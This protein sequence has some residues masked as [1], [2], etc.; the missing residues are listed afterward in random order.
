MKFSWNKE[1]ALIAQIAQIIIALT[2]SIGLDLTAE[3]VIAVFSVCSAIAGF[4][5]RSRVTAPANLAQLNPPP[6]PERLVPRS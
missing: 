6:A 1:P 5:I 4:I 3:Q 2:A